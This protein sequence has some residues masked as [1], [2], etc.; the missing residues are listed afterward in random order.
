MNR[1]SHSIRSSSAQSTWA[2]ASLLFVL[3]AGASQAQNRKYLDQKDGTV[4]D[5]Q[6]GLVWLADADCFRPMPWRRARARVARL[7]DGMCG[8][9][10]GSRPGDWRLPTEKEWEMTVE[11]TCGEITLTDDT[12]RFCFS[13]HG[14]TFRDVQA[15]DYWSS[16]RSPLRG[17]IRVMSLA[18]GRTSGAA[19]GEL[20]PIWPV[21]DE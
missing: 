12:G 13:S 7:Q 18:E 20:L 5:T 11:C 9:T 14:S 8:L 16:T 2:V 4:K 6:T 19:P 17:N 15:S 3:L 10:D 1:P 21:R